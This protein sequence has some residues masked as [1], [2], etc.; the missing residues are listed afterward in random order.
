M[1]SKAYVMR[2]SKFG[3]VGLLDDGRGEAEVVV[4]CERATL[5]RRAQ[6]SRALMQLVM[7]MVFA[8]LRGTRSGKCAWRRTPSERRPTVKH[9]H[10]WTRL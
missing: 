5:K 2:M 4:C 7:G 9:E 6:E 1:V 3:E 10:R 8:L